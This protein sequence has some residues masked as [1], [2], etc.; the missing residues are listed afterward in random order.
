MPVISV[1]VPVYKVEPYLRRCI[2]SILFQTFTDF[3]LILVDDGSPDNCGT[4]CDEYARKDNRVQVIHQENGGLSAARNA[5]IEWSFAHSD[6]EWITFIDSDDWIHKLYLESLYNASNSCDTAI[7]AC[8][9]L[10]TQN[11]EIDDISKITAKK[12]RTNEYWKSPMLAT[13]AWGKLYRKDCFINVR[14][15]VGR[16]HE[17]EYTTYKVL[18]EHEYVSVIDQPLYVYYQNMEGIT[19]RPWNPQRL[20]CFDAL[21]A[22][23][24]YFIDKGYW[25]IAQMSFEAM[26]LKCLQFPELILTSDALPKAEK[27]KYRR[28]V[29]EKL[30][31]TLSN[32]K[33]YKWISIWR[34]GRDLWIYANAYPFIM[35][36]LKIWKPIKTFLKKI[37]FLKSAVQN[38]KKWRRESKIINNYKRKIK[39]CKL[40]LLQTPLHGNLGDQAIALAEADIMDEMGLSF[41]EYPQSIGIESKLAKVTPSDKIIVITGGGFMG[42]LWTNEEQRIRDTFSSFCHNPIIIFPQTVYFNLNSESGKECFETSRKIYESHSNLKLFVREKYSY[43]FIRQNLPEINV[44]LVPDIVMLY[45]TIPNDIERKGC[46]FCIRNDKEKTVT[47]EEIINLQDAVREYFI[48]ISYTDTVVK[49]KINLNN[50]K[51]IVNDKLSEFA[52]AELV[53]T[54]RLH[55][56]IFSAITETPCIVINSLSHKIRG[57]YEWLKDLDYI[58]MVDKLDSLPLIIEQLMKVKPHYDREKIEKAMKPLYDTLREIK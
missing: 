44:E 25:D 8:N 23:I 30:R 14:F 15:P 54:D 32:Y 49:E 48:D 34:R 18:F 21:E 37:P 41:L 24:V 40:I 35:F 7:S 19:R 2:D 58:Q 9:Y 39:N 38:I 27:K 26:V 43:D 36:L 10:E 20:D 13:V 4:I 6:S 55:G 28:I 12:C 42:D 31:N 3:D 57:C 56:M 53:V 16:I 1:I 22:Q 45:R 5:G 17:D 11:N 51:E 47:D 50:R 29:R 46:L 52:S 33:K